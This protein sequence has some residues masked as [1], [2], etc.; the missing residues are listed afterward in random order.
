MRFFNFV[1]LIF[2]RRVKQ[3]ILWRPKYTSQKRTILAYAQ[4]HRIN[5]DC[6]LMEKLTFKQSLEVKSRS[7]YKYLFVKHP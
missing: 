1:S 7:M 5:I 6:I 4:I 2:R 3:L